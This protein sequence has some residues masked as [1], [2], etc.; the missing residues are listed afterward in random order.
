MCR[1]GVTIA[2]FV[3]KGSNGALFV[4][5]KRLANAIESLSHI[6][7]N[8]GIADPT[9]SSHFLENPLKSNVLAL[10]VSALL[11][12]ACA[13]NGTTS[14]KPASGDKSDAGLGGILGSVGSAT[15]Q[16]GVTTSGG[17]DVGLAT[18]A[19]GDLVKAATLTD[20]DIQ[21]SSARSVQ[22]MDKA[23]KGTT[24]GKYGARLKSLTSKFARED[25]L[26]LSFKVYMVKEP[27][28]MAFPD[29]S[30]R[31]T[32]GL[33]DIASNDE[34]RWVVGHEIGHVKLG[35]SASKMKTALM[36]SAARKGVA[37]TSGAAG[38]L[39]ASELG[40]FTE[41]LVNAQYSQG[42]EREAD[43]YGLALMKK[44]KFD[45][46]AAI[47]ILEKFAKMG[48]SSSVLSSHPASADRA[49]RLRSQTGS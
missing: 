36:T 1:P 48:D 23:N 49:Q 43:D 12:T 6:G 21:A 16:A 34:L 3:T 30:I 4:K 26:K 19:A 17:T 7:W 8:I 27:N 37:A 35:H 15:N 38:A 46:K 13:S 28:A 41:S 10:I 18:A 42:A 2:S 14:N 20:K 22:Y 32:S 39:A 11:A 5:Y 29:G 25:G 40:G 31:V 44:Y 33:M 24:A 47:S 45:A 9:V